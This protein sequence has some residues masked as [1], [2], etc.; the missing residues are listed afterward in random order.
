MFKTFLEL[1]YSFEFSKF[2]YIP[3][4]KECNPYQSVI[5]LM[6]SKEHFHFKG[7]IN[8]CGNLSGIILWMVISV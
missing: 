7:F 6:L 1:S 3:Q 5:K 8:S 4:L 2:L